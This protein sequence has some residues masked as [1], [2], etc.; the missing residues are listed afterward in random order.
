MMTGKDLIV[1]ILTN[2]LEN[3]PIFENDRFIGF[4]TAGDVA[5]KMGVGVQTVYVWVY[6]RKLEGFIFGDTLYIPV[7]YEEELARHCQ[8]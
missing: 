7:N 8:E 6:Q 4:V 5:A 2:G 1:Y 3:D